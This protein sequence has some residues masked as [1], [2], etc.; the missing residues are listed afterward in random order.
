M[1]SAHSFE[2]FRNPYRRRLSKHQATS[3]WVQIAGEN[4]YGGV[5]TTPLSGAYHGQDDAIPTVPNVALLQSHSVSSV[6]WTK[7]NSS[8]G[9]DL[10]A[11]AGC[12]KSR[13]SRHSTDAFH[14][15]RSAPVSGSARA[16]SLEENEG[17]GNDVENKRLGDRCFSSPPALSSSSSTESWRTISSESDTSRELP[18]YIPYRRHSLQQIPGLATRPEETQSDIAAHRT[19]PP[20]PPVHYPYSPPVQAEADPAHL[21]RAPSQHG[22]PDDLGDS[23]EAGYRQL[24]SIRFGSLRIT[25]GSP[26]SMRRGEVNMDE[27]AD[28]DGDMNGTQTSSGDA[29]NSH[30][31]LSLESISNED[32]NDSNLT[33]HLPADSS[34]ALPRESRSS[35]QRGETA[36]RRRGRSSGDM[37][38]TSVETILARIPSVIRDE[39]LKLIRRQSTR[40]TADDSSSVC[41]DK[42]IPVMISDDIVQHKQANNDNSNGP[43]LS[44][45]SFRNLIRQNRVKSYLQAN[46]KAAFVEKTS[47][48]R[49]AS[50]QDSAMKATARSPSRSRRKLAKKHPRAASPSAPSSPNIAPYD[51]ETTNQLPLPL[52]TPMGR[53]TGQQGK[54]HASSKSDSQVSEMRF[55]DYEKD[56]APRVARRIE[57]SL[58]DYSEDHRTTY[59]RMPILLDKTSARPRAH[60]SFQGDPP[61]QVNGPIRVEQVRRSQTAEFKPLPTPKP[62]LPQRR[63]LIKI[64]EPVPTGFGNRSS[65]E[66]SMEPRLR[67][68]IYPPMPSHVRSQTMPQVVRQYGPYHDEDED[69]RQLF[70]PN[71]DSP[72]V[73]PLSDEDEDLWPLAP[74][75]S[76]SSTVDQP[77]SSI[78]AREVSPIRH[79]RSLPSIGNRPAR[80]LR[81]PTPISTHSPRAVELAKRWQQQ[82]QQQLQQQRQPARAS[83]E[84]HRLPTFHEHVPSQRPATAGGID[85]YD[86]SPFLNAPIW[87]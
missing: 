50:H 44:F 80:S 48:E 69:P 34:D 60:V 5:P 73:S 78:H 17:L 84:Q 40:V 33:A 87:G 41:S 26:L 52:E 42:F 29:D 4:D 49:T 65:Q 30:H 37:S 59:E 47:H 55:P 74:H 75:D 85:E 61:K 72:F 77:S 86:D 32:F 36:Q 3:N 21:L 23:T 79:A 13:P 43:H 57:R 63:R 10:S 39:Q 24:G 56:L 38:R 35:V 22:G 53:N 12:Y 11:P 7:N 20:A 62:E 67:Q 19:K 82:Q 27:E 18:H 25:N 6:Q 46:T 66:S 8:L 58:C 70:S 9:H 71:N 2:D 81:T 14:P 83:L 68:D 15:L 45:Q 1:G 16:A 54:G 31:A 64:P 76:S 28:L 51:H